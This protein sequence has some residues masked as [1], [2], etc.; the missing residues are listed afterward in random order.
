MGGAAMAA[1]VTGRAPGAINTTLPN[2]GGVGSAGWS[3]LNDGTYSITGVSNGNWVTPATAASAAY[4]EVKVDV[5]SGSFATGTT[6]S[7]LS[8]G[9]TRSWTATGSVQFTVTIREILTG[10]VRSTQTGLTLTVT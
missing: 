4:Y 9:T 1:L 10:I 6:G 5:T 7:Y 3:L 2:G 8:L